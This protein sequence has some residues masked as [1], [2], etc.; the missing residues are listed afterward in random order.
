MKRPVPRRVALRLRRPARRM[1]EEGDW[2][3]AAEARWDRMFGG[4]RRV[5]YPCESC[6]HQAIC[7]HTDL[8]C[9]AFAR[10]FSRAYDDAARRL[11]RA[12]KP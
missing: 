3:R 8:Y 7:G 5:A 6:I 9:P 4:Y 11:R 10:W 2:Q 1:A 12:T